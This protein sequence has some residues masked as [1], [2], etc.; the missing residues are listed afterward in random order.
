M[1]AA[2]IINM[3]EKTWSIIEGGAPSSKINSSTANAVPHVDDWKSLVGSQGP[4]TIWMRRSNRVGWPFDDYVNVD[5]EI[6]LKF[7]YGATYHGGGGFIPNIWVEVPVC[8]VG[9][10]YSIDVDIHIHNPTNAN[11][12]TAPLAKVPVSISGTMSNPFWSSRV[13]WGFTLYGNGNWERN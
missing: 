6:D 3:A 2:D 5:F 13:E 11:T 8:F 9:W 10:H 7:E 12:E 4:K 1:S